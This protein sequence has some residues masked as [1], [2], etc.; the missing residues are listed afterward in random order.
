MTVNAGLPLPIPTG[1]LWCSL[2]LVLSDAGSIS[3]NRGVVFECCP[4][5]RVMAMPQPKNYRP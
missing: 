2:E 1:V 5:D 4:R 3:S